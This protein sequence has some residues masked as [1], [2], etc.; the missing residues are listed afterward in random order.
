MKF[1]KLED[2]YDFASAGAPQDHQAYVSKSTGKTFW[3]SD[4]LDIDQRPE[5]FDESD[6][7][8]E[9][10]HKKDLDLDQ[11]LIWRFVDQAAPEKYDEVRR[12]FSRRGAYRRYRSFLEREGLLD[13]WYAFEATQTR[14]ALLEWCDDNGIEVEDR[15]RLR[16]G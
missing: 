12:I 13:K 2:A 16:L 14:E 8:V 10:P 9:I 3:Y 7:Y 4:F 5:D 11:R 6:D 1:R 15:D